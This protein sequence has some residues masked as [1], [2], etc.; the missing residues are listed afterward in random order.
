MINFKN[1]D[2]KRSIEIIQERDE[3]VIHFEDD[4]NC[5]PPYYLV[6]GDSSFFYHNKEDRAYDLNSFLSVVAG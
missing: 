3:Y 1:Q 4:F 2:L 5:D 6:I